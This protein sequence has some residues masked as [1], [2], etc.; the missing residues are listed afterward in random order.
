MLPGLFDILNTDQMLNPSGAATIPVT[1][2]ALDFAG[3]DAGS[4]Q[5]TIINRGTIRG[6]ALSSSG[7]SPAGDAALAAGAGFDRAGAR[8]HRRRH[9]AWGGHRYVPSDR[10]CI[11]GRV[12]GMGCNDLII[13]GVMT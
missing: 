3:K 4:A 9:L 6:P 11:S 7:T 1:E 13:G 5:A 2:R 10:A 12:H 8:Y